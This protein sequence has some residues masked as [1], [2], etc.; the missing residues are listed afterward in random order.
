MHA[1]IADNPDCDC[2]T[3]AIMPTSGVQLEFGTRT[4]KHKMK[5][6]VQSRR[7]LAGHQEDVPS[8]AQVKSVGILMS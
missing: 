8:K 2:F 5:K 4:I 3:A 6:E 1:F 7:N